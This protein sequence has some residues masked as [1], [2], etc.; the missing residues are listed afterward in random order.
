MLKSDNLSPRQFCLQSRIF[1]PCHCGKKNERMFLFLVPYVYKFIVL[2]LCQG[3]GPQSSNESLG[4]LTSSGSH[5]K[6]AQGQEIS[7]SFS[8][9]SHHPIA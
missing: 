2:K 6:V 5:V 8:E 3:T 7:H 4:V 1:I 9:L